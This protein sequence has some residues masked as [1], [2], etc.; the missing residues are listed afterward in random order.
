MAA[1]RSSSPSEQSDGAAFAAERRSAGE[2]TDI[3]DPIPIPSD[4]S[5]R[6]SDH[7]GRTDR[8]F[9]VVRR[10]GRWSDVLRLTAD[11]PAVIGRGSGNAVTIRSHQASRRHAE[12]RWD[13]GDW[14]LSDL[15]SRNGTRLAGRK[16]TQP[17]RLSD[18]DQIEIAGFVLV[19]VTRVADALALPPADGGSEP[20]ATDDQITF[21]GQDRADIIHRLHE[22]R[23]LDR[24]AA[25]PTAVGGTP[26]RASMSDRAEQTD[27]PVLFRLALALATAES[28][29]QAAESTLEALS[30]AIP[31]CH[32]GIFL[33]Q[34]MVEPG[35][36]AKSPP[37]SVSATSPQPELI[38]FTAG[39]RSYRRPTPAVV[40]A[41]T[42]GDQAVLV[43][44][45]G[46]DAELQTADSRGEL[47]IQSVILAP[48]TGSSSS[49]PRRLGYLH[50]YRSLPDGELTS[51]ELELTAAAAGVFAAAIENLSQRGRLIR[52]LR[53][54][55]QTVDSLRQRLDEAVRIIGESPPIGRLREVIRRVSMSDATVLV[56]G[57]SGVGK[58]L[59][60]GAIHQSSRRRDGPLVC[61]NCAALSPTLLES[62]LFGHEKG[63]F[64]GA[65]D[66]KKGK[67][68]AADG[69]TLML[70][71]IGEMD[72]NLQAKLL[73]VLEGHPFERLGGHTPLRVDVRLIAATN[74][75]LV[76]EVAE[77]RFRSDL[78]YRLNVIEIV[79]PPLRERGDD[80]LRIA[81]HFVAHFAEKTARLIEGLTPAARDRLLSHPWP[82]NVRELK[83]VI[84]RAVVL[85]N[86]AVIDVDD[87]ALPTSRSA[88]DPVARTLD[89]ADTAKD[90]PS[91]NDTELPSLAELERRHLLEVLRRTG[92][93]KSRAAA[94]LGIERSTL[95]RKLKRQGIT[96]TDYR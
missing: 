21:T 69:G 55:R 86:T 77:G 15:G 44:N 40:A 80:V 95:D 27:W 58:E 84:E 2:T 23:Y 42:G 74:R 83:N 45:A 36:D 60:A 14:W 85:G 50:L 81:D 79:V 61:L 16:I 94:V 29:E 34:P 68:E 76:A 22:S 24:P 59:V 75:D 10:G 30:V 54:S 8:A 62:E 4:H 6:P 26:D 93:N 43:R 18:G 48:I 89:Q 37:E 57:E 39:H 91:G 19:F 53:R 87:L 52:S 78:Y 25:E 71:E 47:V 7:S 20:A 1:N 11:R 12:L 64:T 88:N 56:R 49:P 33:A 3:V 66:R 70:D 31:G 96:P 38:A 67:F 32:G 51:R 5:G 63:A 35:R 13:D 65:T 72:V 28:L 92:G 41:V 90:R 9:V 82:G 73:R 46:D 17:C